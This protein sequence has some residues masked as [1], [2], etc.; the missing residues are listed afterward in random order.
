MDRDISYTDPARELADLLAT[1]QM[2]ENSKGPGSVFLAKKFGVEPWSHEFYRIIY[3]IMGRLSNITLIVD[4]LDREHDI[5]EDFKVEL[6]RH[7]EDI[8]TAFSPSGLQAAW[9]AFGAKKMAA[10]NILSIRSL[11]VSI[12]QKIKYKKLNEEEL[13]ELTD[14]VEDLLIWLNEHQLYEQEFIRQA[15][16]EG[17]ENL[18]FRLKHIQWLGW[19]YTLE[20][21]REV[22]SAYMMLERDQIKNNANPDAEAMLKKVASALRVIHSRIQNVKSASETADWLLRMYA[23]THLAQNHLPVVK[24]FLTSG[25]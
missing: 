13:S 3:T 25:G 17:L 24:G 22:I 6:I 12:R 7:V 15:L 5:D 21:V 23:A 19:G 9:D 14:I 18:Q 2:G 11:S 10:V 4:N 20:S 8:A 1:L 16:I